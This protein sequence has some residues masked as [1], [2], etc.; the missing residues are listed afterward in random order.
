MG[1]VS[2]ADAPG[3]NELGSLVNNEPQK[4]GPKYCTGPGRFTGGLVRH[5]IRQI[6]AEGAAAQVR[7]PANSLIGEF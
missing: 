3:V 5:N 1:G 4:R 7:E 2:I 6:Y